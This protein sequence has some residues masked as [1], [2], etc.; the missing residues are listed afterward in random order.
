[1]ASRV[2][3]RLLAGAVSAVVVALT[4]GAADAPARGSA[5]PAN[6]GQ[7]TI[8]GIAAE[9]QIV[10]GHNGSWF[11]EPACVPSGPENRGGYEFQWQRCDAAGA[12][13]ANIADA[14]EQNYT[15]AAADRGSTLRV[16][17][18][19][20][21]YDCNAHGVDC[22]Y[23][24]A[25]AFSAVTS[26]VPGA[27]PAPPPPP[28][29]PPGP[30]DGPPISNA[31]PVVAGVAQQGQ[32]L[33]ASSGDWSGVAPIGYT[34]R[35]N[36]CGASCATI[37]GAT[38]TR[39]TAG[40]ADVGAKLTVT[41]TATNELGS[42]TANSAPSSVVAPIPSEAPVSMSPP[43]VFGT[44][45]EGATLTVAPGSWSGSP[46]PVFSFGWLRCERA[47]GLCLPIVGADG[48]HYVLRAEDG[49]R[50]LRAVVT[51]SNSAGTA[52]A[53]SAPTGVVAPSGLLHL[54]D[55]RDSV[56]ANGVTPPDRLRI[57]R[58][59][60]RFAGAGTVVATLH[61]SDTRGYVVRGALVSIRPARNGE[62]SS[63]R[64]GTTSTD[65]T[66]TVFFT[67]GAARRSRGGNLVLVVRATRRG[68][69]SR[70]SVA[71]SVRITLRLRPRA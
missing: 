53:A 21:N 62:I 66:A 15:V 47:F 54:L 17:V 41:V 4:A 68:D 58:A 70:S 7:P 22:R 30:D 29:P 24:S 37:A 20:T 35:W 69:D 5:G 50:E 26:A 56:P 36:R 51:A 1:M 39:Y 60:F 65:G 38:G 61:V 71:G 49:G 46:A 45:K 44:P 43:A 63:A 31:L 55:G 42:A 19:A 12:Q 3:S 48:P 11:C 57:D 16:A 32:T 67:V 18:T 9:G 64:P 33:T 34:Y 13:C 52:T 8:T 23:S 14:D 10:T 25:T 2:R 40:S 59:R 27:P 28:P 6:N